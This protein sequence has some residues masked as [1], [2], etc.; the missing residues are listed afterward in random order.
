MYGHYQSNPD[1]EFLGE[2]SQDLVDHQGIM[3]RQHSFANFN[4]KEEKTATETVS[5]YAPT[6]NQFSIGDKVKHIT[7]GE[8]VV[9]MIDK[10]KVT[11]A[12]KAEYGIKVLMKDHPS[13]QKI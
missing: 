8:G 6:K 2:I 12:F 5:S 4:K 3:K 10:D 13:I 1:S 9:V 7:F 11:I